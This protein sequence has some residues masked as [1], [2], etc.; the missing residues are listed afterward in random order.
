MWTSGLIPA[1]VFFW[2][3]HNVLPI[4][5]NQISESPLRYSHTILFYSPPS[6]SGVSSVGCVSFP[7][8][9]GSHPMGAR[10]G[11]SELRSLF[12]T[13]IFLTMAFSYQRL[14]SICYIVIISKGAENV[15]SFLIYFIAINS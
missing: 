12:L 9:I 7:S 13:V 11:G 14:I 3:L 8:Y 4:K 1:P 6:S 15:K 10:E 5:V 2:H